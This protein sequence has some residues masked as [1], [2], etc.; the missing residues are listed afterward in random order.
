MS[1]FALDYS[2]F[3]GVLLS[4][5]GLGPARSGVEVDHASVRVRMGWAFRAELPRSAVR[6]ASRQERLPFPG[7]GVHGWRGRWLV[8]GSS[9]GLVRIELEPAS[10]ARTVGFRISLRE[11]WLSLEQPDELVAVLRR[12]D[13]SA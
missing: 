3:N 12:D 11:L 7:W 1:S 5:L 9:R 6:A 2:R 4:L 8:N 13:G 10:T